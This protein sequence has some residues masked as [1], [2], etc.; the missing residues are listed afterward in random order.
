MIVFLTALNMP[1]LP[2]EP[3]IF[4][5][6]SVS[7]NMSVL[8]DLERFAPRPLFQTVGIVELSPVAVEEV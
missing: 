6:L 8:T 2:T 7:T 1:L 3:G 5:F 4:S